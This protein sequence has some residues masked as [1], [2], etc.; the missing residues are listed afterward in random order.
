MSF[1]QPLAEKMVFLR[2]ATIAININRLTNA[3]IDSRNYRHRNISLY[4]DKCI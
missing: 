3:V 4:T 1:H 2:I